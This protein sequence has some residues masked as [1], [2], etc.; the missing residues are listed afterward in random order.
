MDPSTSHSPTEPS[1]SIRPKSVGP[2]L[3]LVLGLGVAAGIF[4]RD[5]AERA[6]EH[7]NEGLFTTEQVFGLFGA[8]ALAIASV[9]VFIAFPER[10]YASTSG[11]TSVR[12]VL[13]KWSRT[14]DKERIEKVT[15]VPGFV[16][17]AGKTL[18]YYD[19][20]GHW[21]ERSKRLRRFSE[22]GEATARA[23]AW[24]A[25]WDAELVSNST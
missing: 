18:H 11:L 15:V 8:L 21:G 3:L 13:A 12:G 7:I 14:V 6:M 16:R 17:K 23:T 2:V 4:Y 20:Y 22:R 5:Y 9:V 19:V 10:L 1:E 24:S 25:L